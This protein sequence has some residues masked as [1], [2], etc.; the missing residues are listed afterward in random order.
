ML[1]IVVVSS[2]E[3]QTNFVMDCLEN[4]KITKVC[5]IG[6]GYV[7]ALTSLVIACKCPHIRV[8]VVD[9]NE[10]RIASWNSNELPIYE[11]IWKVVCFI[12][13]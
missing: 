6:A 8:A 3:L 9:I 4:A 1:F 13:Y 7:G 10:S 5:C 11:V 2:S 12:F